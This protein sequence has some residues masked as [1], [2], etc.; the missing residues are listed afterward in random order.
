MNFSMTKSVLSPM[1]IKSTLSISLL[2][3]VPLS[4]L[5]GQKPQTRLVSSSQEVQRS[6][7][8]G[9]MVDWCLSR[10]LVKGKSGT[11]TYHLC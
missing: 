11:Q 1:T 8:R 10:H 6:E 4:D 2:F 5:T 7:V 3:K 9:V